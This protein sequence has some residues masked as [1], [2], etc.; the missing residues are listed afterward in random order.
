MPARDRIHYP[1]KNALTKA[2]WR[3]TDDPYTIEYEEM[4][5]FADLAADQPL[6]AAERHGD[7]IVVEIKSFSGRSPVH[8]LEEALGQYVVYMGL[9]TEAAPERKLYLAIADTVH[10]ELF[11]LKAVVTILRCQPMSLIVVDV[12]AEEVVRWIG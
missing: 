1:V 6:L 9:L 12:E 10:D 7:K 11:S 3:I 2:G 4:T 5:V 8:D